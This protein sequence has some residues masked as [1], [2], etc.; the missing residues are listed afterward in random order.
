MNL[1][2]NTRPDDLAKTST[3]LLIIKRPY[4]SGV[5]LAIFCLLAALVGVVSALPASAQGIRF[6][7]N[8]LRATVSVGST[9]NP[10]LGAN[11]NTNNTVV[12]VNG[13]TNASFD[14]SGLP[15]GVFA[16]LVDASGNALPSTTRSTNLIVQL[17]VTNLAAGVYNFS[18]NAGGLDTNG[19]PVT[20][21]FPFVLQSA[22]IWKGGGLGVSNNWANATSWQGTAGVPTASSDVVFSDSGAQTNNTFA[23]G[24]WFT[25]VGIDANVTVASI[26]F[27]Q[28][29]YTNAL[30][31]NSFYHGIRLAPN[32]TL[33]VTGTNGF[34]LLRDYIS[35]FG[36]SPDST[37]GVRITG[38]N[39]TMMVSNEAANFAINVGGGQHPT[40]S[41]SNL[42]ALITYVSRVGFSD[43]QLYPNYR[44]LNDGF[45]GGRDTTNYGSSPRTFWN[46]VYL[47]R[48]NFITAT[49]K[50]PDNY[51]N[52]FTRGYALMLQNNEQNG[53]GSSVNT[54]FLLGVTN[55][56]KMDGIC[57]VGASSASGNT[58][59]VKFGTNRLSA[60]IF[61]GTNDGRMS[62]F[63]IADDGGTNNASSNVKATIDFTGNTNYVD[64][65]ADRLYIARDRTMIVSNQTPNVQGDLT[66]GYGN[67]DV[68][69]AVLG[70]QEHSNKVDW[71]TLY[72]AQPYLN[73]CQA[74]LVLTN[75]SAFGQYGATFKVNGNLTLGYT[76]DM[77]PSGSAQQY[78]TFG[79]ITIYS[80]AV[81]Q[82]SNIICDGG[83]NFYN[84]S[85]RQNSI[86]INQGG[87]LIVTN[88]VGYPNLGAADFSAADSR[89]MLLDVLN[90][91]AGK[92]TIFVDPSKTNVY[93]RSLQTPG[94]VPGVIKV[95]A[96]TGVSSFPAQI[97]VI[98]YQ[99]SASPFLTADV[100]SLGA[101][102]FGFVLNNAANQTVDLFITTNPPN[103]LIWTGAAS[104]QW[105]TTSINW[106]TAVGGTPT[107]FSLGDAVTFNDSSTVTNI[108]ISGSVVPS[109]TGVGV[110]ISNNL[111][112]YSFSGGVI[113]GTALLVKRGTNSLQMDA[114][115]Q[116]P[117]NVMAGS[118]FGGGGGGLGL[119]T[120]WT[121]TSLNFG[122]SIN[123]GL[124][125]T[126]VVNLVSGSTLTGPVSIQAGYLVN[127][128]IINVPQGSSFLMANGV[129]V[130]NDSG[131]TIT[132][133]SVPVSA[134]G[135][136]QVPYGSTLANMGTIYLWQN[137]IL[138]SGVL[139]GTGTI[140]NPNGGGRGA[141]S[142]IGFVRVQGGGIISAGTNLDNHVSTMNMYARFDWNNDPTA[143]ANGL[144]PGILRVD[145][146]FSNPQT[147]DIINCDYWNNITGTLLM[148]N[149]NTG[150]GSF[151]N[152]QSFQIFNNSS[153][154][155][156]NFIDTAGFCPNIQPLVPGAGLVWSV[157]NFNVYGL[158]AITTNSMVWNGTAT[159]TWVTNTPAETSWKTGQAFTDAQGA[160]FDDSASGSSTVN[161]SGTLAPAG[162]TSPPISNNPSIFPGVVVSNNVKSYVFAGTGKISG[163]TS[164]YKTG[165]GTMTLLTSNDFTGNIYLEKGTLV[166][167]NNGA[168]GSLTSLG[169]T[170]GGQMKNQ[171]EFSGGTL[172]YVGTTNVNLPN[173]TVFNESGGTINVA[174]PANYLRLTRSQIGV[175]T[176][177]KTGPG[178][179]L[180]DQGNATYS[181]GGLTSPA[182][183]GGFI[184]NA[185]FLRLGV[186]SGGIG[187]GALTLNGGGLLTTNFNLTLT[188]TI[189]VTA[190]STVVVQPGCTNALTGPVI[191]SASLTFTNTSGGAFAFAGEMSNYS[192]TLSFGSSTANYLFNNATN[193]NPCTGSALASFNLGTGSSTL[194][195]YNG[196]ALT[197]HLGA[198][199][200]GANTILAG[201]VTNNTFATAS[202]TYAIGAN[203]ANTTFSGK[204]QN[205]QDT[206]S[207]VK[208]GSGSLFLNGASTY[209][210]STTVSNGVLGG[211]GSITSPLTVLAGG[212]LAP[213]TS[214]G[215][216]TVNN[217]ATLG[218]ITL[219]ELNQANAG[220]TNDLLVVTG[221]LVGGGALVVT[222]VGPT[223]T[224]GSTF[225]LFSQAVTGFSSIIL[226]NGG[227]VWTT[228]LAVNG[229]ITL[230]SGGVST[231][232]IGSTNILTSVSGNTLTLTWPADH[233]GWRLQVQTNTLGVGLYTNWTDVAGSTTTNSVNFLMNPNNGS[234]FY[235]IVYP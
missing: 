223:I 38:L 86:T 141:S 3:E 208:M 136:W 206:V 166:V 171:I 96:L 30:V 89:G 155:L 7:F 23:G 27:A 184:V 48:T 204:I 131:A 93:V 209:T 91:Q 18:L 102:Y 53:N 115:E 16:A 194:S 13:C 98:S 20:N 160:L 61:R 1:N 116:G 207:V 41:I 120:L 228:N 59:G 28:T 190:G 22:H 229:S 54:F 92:L 39:S 103:N 110:T 135:D 126:G 11:P 222:N 181:A 26:R 213:G 73:Y 101:G 188:N 51:T 44:A 163:P 67:V 108:S 178:T 62:V 79:R 75:G 74:R 225:K 186:S 104:S 88:A 139:F 152:G 214:V 192:G 149:I 231:V 129:G 25:N 46:N 151:A 127:G 189:N 60:A 164:L 34:G 125:S 235:R 169:I 180:V 148:T 226:P 232:N 173:Y 50:N 221:T 94:I 219:M 154:N 185:G 76:A 191:G 85:G 81:L 45:N 138:V 68:N 40:L 187:S 119:T 199:S 215:T 210:G 234:V 78:N 100:S 49:Y 168:L 83:L 8:Q 218:G 24:V 58:G 227:Y 80:N 33:S 176:L 70:Y 99:G 172:N 117:I 137:R 64:I 179:L 122:G 220:Q 167:S 165:P 109:Q 212:T 47:A 71:T 233:T 36:Y 158:I 52:E 14:L 146:D 182:H 124:T 170:G 97:P 114:V 63:T 211:N 202:S 143:A 106:V 153:G 174:S 121:N 147:N 133:G 29:A 162:I 150:A 156:T 201:R 128:G 112:S 144:L 55:V 2:H 5:K 69:T 57:L 66:V 230:V 161:V 77:N 196:A 132:S 142:G 224:N 37:M 9:N 145:V 35:D 205:G 32:T 216:F 17:Y 183:T 65:L 87:N 43:Y 4:L 31:T 134:G 56:F 123:G 105:D 95:A 157:T 82:A 111:Y 21:K 130:T 118:V 10:T 72:G 19:L 159:A 198:L 197:Y 175:G 6:Q 177:T 84:G 90:I 12:L 203:G 107:N 113:A 15:A 217:N 42:G 200:G 195:N 193:G 140:Q